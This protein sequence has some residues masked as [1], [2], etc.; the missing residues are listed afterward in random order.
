LTAD[1]LGGILA[2]GTDRF[3]AFPFPPADDLSPTLTFTTLSFTT[4]SFNVEGAH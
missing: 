1:G 2:F 3:W 4:L